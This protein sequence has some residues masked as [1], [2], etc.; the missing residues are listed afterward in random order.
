MFISGT[1][2]NWKDLLPCCFLVP[3]GSRQLPL[4]PVIWESVVVS[5]MICGVLALGRPAL[6]LGRTG[7][8]NG[9]F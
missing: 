4:D 7:V 3:V 8:K 5:P 2:G 1:D 6:S 9:T